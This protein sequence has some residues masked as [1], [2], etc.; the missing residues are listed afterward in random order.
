L[1]ALIPPSPEQKAVLY[2]PENDQDHT[3]VYMHTEAGSTFANSLSELA[4]RRVTDARL[5]IE[6]KQLLDGA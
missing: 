1:K 5:S 6:V 3:V 4:W 2:L